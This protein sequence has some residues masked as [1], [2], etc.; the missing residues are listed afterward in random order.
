MHEYKIDVLRVVDGDT[1]DV[2]IDLGFESLYAA[3][4]AMVTISLTLAPTL[5]ICAEWFN[6]VNN[7]PIVF[8]APTSPT[9]LE[10]MFAACN[11]GIT[12]ILAGLDSLLKG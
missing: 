8:P 10:A 4:R 1:V 6:P 9:N 7:G 3:N 11:P 5:T 2:D 12:K